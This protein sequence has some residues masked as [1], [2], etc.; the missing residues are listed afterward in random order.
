MATPRLYRADAIV[1]KRTD[2]GEADRIIT[3]YTPHH[4]KLRAIAKGVRKTT[5]RLAGHLELFTS[6]HVQLARGRELEVI[7]QSMTEEAYRG[8]R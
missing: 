7:T 6:A 1:L 8:L 3:L 4:G 2:V 5:S